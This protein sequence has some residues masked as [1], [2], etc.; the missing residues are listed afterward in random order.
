MATG[1]Q[2]GIIQSKFEALGYDLTS[3]DD[4][5][6]VLRRVARLAGTGDL[7]DLNQL[8]QERADSVKAQLKGCGDVTDL[9]RLL[10]DGEV[11][12]NA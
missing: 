11:P 6:A 2:V 1:G 8:T 4:Q 12:S 7:T 3:P 5:Q 10:E 9:D